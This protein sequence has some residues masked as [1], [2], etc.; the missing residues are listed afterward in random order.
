MKSCVGWGPK[1][2]LPVGIDPAGT[3]SADGL[4]IMGISSLH[5][6]RVLMDVSTL[7]TSDSHPPT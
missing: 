4:E 6:H 1:A 5:P 7:L 3:G 2:P